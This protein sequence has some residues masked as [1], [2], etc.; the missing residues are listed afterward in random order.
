LSEGNIGFHVIREALVAGLSN[1]ANGR[2]AA[3]KAIQNLDVTR[4]DYYIDKVFEGLEAAGLIK[5]KTPK[6]ET[7]RER[8]TRGKCSAPR[9]AE[10]PL[11]RVPAPLLGV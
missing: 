10:R 9:G 4:F 7:R 11:R 3:T 5:P 8:M 1:P 2:G 6:A